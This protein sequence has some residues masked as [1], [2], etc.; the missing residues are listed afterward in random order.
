MEAVA[1]GKD[2]NYA[3]KLI[4]DGENGV[5]IVKRIAIELGDIS[6]GGYI[7]KKGLSVGDLVAVAGL[8]ALYDGKKVK[9]LK[10]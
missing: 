2:G 8:R 1:S 9:L 10:N 6:S 3:F 7:I 4:P 5:Y